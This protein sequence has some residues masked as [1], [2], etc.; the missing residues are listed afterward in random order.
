MQSRMIPSALASVALALSVL[1]SAVIVYANNATEFTPPQL[2]HLSFYI[3]LA[4]AAGAVAFAIAAVLGFRAHVTTILVTLSG[5]AFL[6]N[7]IFASEVPP[8]DGAEHGYNPEF[9]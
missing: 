9:G 7:F 6:A 5:L 2:D 4:L 3:M 8:I 1:A